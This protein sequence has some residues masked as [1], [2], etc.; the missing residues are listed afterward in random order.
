[1]SLS[2][3]GGRNKLYRHQLPV[4]SFTRAASAPHF[5][6]PEAHY[7]EIPLKESTDW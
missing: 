1:M 6:A 5:L 2:L 3:G 4:A 7:P